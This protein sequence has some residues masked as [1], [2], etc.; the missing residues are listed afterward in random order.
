[1][2]YRRL[3]KSGLQV[4]VLGLGTNNFGGRIDEA[5]SVRVIDQAIETGVNFFDTANVY[6]GSM[7][8][9]II[10]K[11]LKGRRDKVVLCTKFGLS[12]GK[13]PN[14]KGGSRM[15]IQDSVEASLRRLQTEYIDLY[16]QHFMDPETPIEETL[17]ALD[18][19]VHQGKV[20][21]IGCGNFDAWRACEAE[22]ASRALN[23][24]RYICAQNHY[25]LL[26]RDVEKDLAPFCKAYGVALIPYFPLE[27]GLLT[28]KY[29]QGEPIPKGTRMEQSPNMQ[30]VLNEKNFAKVTTLERFAQ[31]RGHAIGELAHAWLLANP[32][33]PSVISGA[34]KPEQVAHNAKGLDWKLTPDDLKEIDTICPV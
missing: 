14:L 15:H 23:L 29:R 33:V 20:R 31:E 21:Y 30:R 34:T 28:G 8:E 6:G 2:E 25:N 13:G 16:M 22:W 26:K 3:G 27:S 18:D 1:M 19:L 11:A 4:S 7:S 10:G 12:T 9:Q 32:A 5:A 17:G 24:N